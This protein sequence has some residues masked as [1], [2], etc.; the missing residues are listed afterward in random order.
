M[1]SGASDA[2][3]SN[4]PND[5]DTNA[6]V[7]SP[8]TLPH[9]EAISAYTPAWIRWPG[10]WGDGAG[11]WTGSGGKSPTGPAT[12]SSWKDPVDWDSNAVK[13]GHNA[14]VACP[15]GPPPAQAARVGTH[16]LRTHSTAGAGAG[17][18]IRWTRAGRGELRVTWSLAKGKST[19]APVTLE[20]DVHTTR[21]LFPASVKNV[22]LRT[23]RRHGTVVLRLP[24]TRG[25]FE[26]VGQVLRKD[27]RWSS[28]TTRSVPTG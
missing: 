14:N 16:R 23:G 7:N 9:V 27:G 4:D 28:E 13:G 3:G 22:S 20:L 26:L 21:V 15:D 12:F 6:T 19:S 8:S 18:S 11:D 1:P 17:P 2:D 24:R 25:P 5:D 10:R